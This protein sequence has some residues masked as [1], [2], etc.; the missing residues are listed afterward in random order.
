[1]SST[2]DEKLLKS[3]PGLMLLNVTKNPQTNPPP[4]PSFIVV[5]SCFKELGTLDAF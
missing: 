3:L 2:A 4:P 1:M 5:S